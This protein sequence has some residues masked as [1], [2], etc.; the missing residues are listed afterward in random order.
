MAD[1]WT[2]LE[3][4]ALKFAN[5]HA[6]RCGVCINKLYYAQH[7]DCY[8]SRY[9]IAAARAGDAARPCCFD[10]PPDAVVTDHDCALNRVLPGVISGTIDELIGKQ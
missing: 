4:A 1:E 8:M 10:L 3:E 9:I 7:P 6:Q 2:E 5:D